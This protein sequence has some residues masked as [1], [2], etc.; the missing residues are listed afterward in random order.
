MFFWGLDREGVDGGVYIILIIFILKWIDLFVNGWFK[1]ISIEFLV[2]LWI[3]LLVCCLGLIVMVIVLLIF[4]WVLVGK[5]LCVKCCISLG[6]CVLN[7]VGVSLKLFCFGVF[8]LI[9]WFFSGGVNLLVLSWKVEG[10]LFMVL[11]NLWF[12]YIRW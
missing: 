6:L 4:S 12:L 11:I 2:I 10:L 1:L 8:M 3:S 9:R 5:L 7:V